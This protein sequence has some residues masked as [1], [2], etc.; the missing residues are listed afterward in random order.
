MMKTSSSGL[1]KTDV[2]RKTQ[3]YEA[4]WKQSAVGKWQRSG[5]DNIFADGGWDRHVNAPIVIDLTE[6][7]NEED[8]IKGMKEKEL[9]TGE[10]D[11]S[12]MQ[13]EKERATEDKHME[14]FYQCEALKMEYAKYYP[15]CTIPNYW[16][17]MAF[18]EDLV[19]GE[20]RKAHERDIP[21]QI[22]GGP[23]KKEWCTVTKTYV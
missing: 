21:R 17:P 15:G 20:T 3:N 23:W 19:T 13:K 7:R 4:R 6:E 2:N 5:N 14:R 16:L 18:I 8:S 11:Q 9:E 10:R 1:M 22:E 12:S